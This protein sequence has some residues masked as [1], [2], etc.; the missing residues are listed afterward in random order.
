MNGPIAP[1]QSTH[2]K[3]A[4]PRGIRWSWIFLLVVVG[5][6][7]LGLYFG[8]PWIRGR[9][10]NR[11]SG[12]PIP[13]ILISIDTLRADAVSGF[14]GAPTQT[15]ELL[16]FGNESIRCINAISASH[17]TAPSHA[18]MLTG[19]SPFV[20]GCAMG[21]QGKAWKIGAGIPTI[22]ETLKK[23]GYRTGAFTDGVQLIPEGGFS[24]GFDVYTYKSN[25]LEAKLRGIEKFLEQ[26]PEQTKFLFLHT[27]RAHVPY[28]PPAD[29]VDALVENY[30][31]VF[32][33]AA[34]E[35]SKM[36]HEQMI[37]PSFVQNQIGSKLKTSNAKNQEDVEFLKKMYLSGVT[38]A[39][40]EIGKVLAL[41]KKVDIYDRAIIVITSDHGE[42]FKEH[43]F[44]SHTNVY[45][46]CVRVPLMIRLPGGA[47]AG[48]TVAEMFGSVN[49]VPTLLELANVG[50]D[51]AYEGDSFADGLS[52]GK[53]TEKPAITAWYYKSGVQWPTGRC[54]RSRLGKYMFL[55][56][57]EPTPEWVKTLGSN[58]YFDLAKDA[59]EMHN[60]AGSGGDEEIRLKK[61]LELAESDWS[62]LRKRHHTA[63]GG[64]LDLDDEALQNLEAIGYAGKGTA[65]KP[66]TKPDK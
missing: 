62:V 52:G 42:A 22:A 66:D 2:S 28:R 1:H 41:L 4:Q 21:G 20:H 8:I 9:G 40:R 60:I 30:H 11:H 48:S 27:Y 58:V 59:P 6:A 26:N 34:L 38:G 51:I 57:P 23:A 36:T 12:P 15:P 32:R 13:I 33:D 16:R 65:S 61:I 45:D 17:I 18:T 55:E 7:G 3:P 63:D 31:G 54:A 35:A 43:G 5:A 46:E 44:D 25:G 39:D 49:L 19:F 24:R 50:I 56:M 37:R 10:A 14:G 47:A 29:L 53:I 64:A